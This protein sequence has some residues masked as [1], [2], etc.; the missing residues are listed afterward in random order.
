MSPRLWLPA[1]LFLSLGVGPLFAETPLRWQW[2]EN[3]QFFVEWR[4]VKTSTGE[5]LGSLFSS[6]QTTTVLLGFTVQRT[7]PD[8]GVVLEERI[9]SVKDEVEGGNADFLPGMLEGTVLHATL[10]HLGKVV[11][12]EGSQSVVKRIMG[13]NSGPKGDLL[14]AMVEDQCKGWLDDVFILLPE[15]PLPGGGKWEQ[16]TEMHLTGFGRQV[17]NKTFTDE[18]AVTIYGRQAH[19][20]TVQGTDVLLPPNRD[21]SAMAITKC[22]AKLTK[23]DYKGT[24][25]FDPAAGR[26]LQSETT[27]WTDMNTSFE[28][29][30]K[31]FEAGGT[32]NQTTK[33]RFLT[34]DPRPAPS[35]AGVDE[36]AGMVKEFTNSLG[37]KLVRIPRGQ[38]LMGSALTEE[39]RHESEHQ[40]LVEITHPFFMGVHEATIG[41]YRQFVQATGYQTFSEK[42]GKGCFGYNAAS[43]KVESGLIYSWKNPGW[44]HTDEHPVVNLSWF[45]AKAFC[46]WLSSKEGRTYRLPTEAEWEYACRAGTTTQYS[47]GTDPETLTAVGNVTDSSAKK[48]FPQWRTIRG[49]DGYTFTAPVGRFK[50][51]AFGLYD[52]HGNALEWC[53]DWYWLYDEESRKDPKGPPTGTH[54]IQ[55]GGSWAD[56]PDQCRSSSRAAFAP[57]SWC[58]SSGFRVVAEDL[59]SGEK[60]SLPAVSSEL[61]QPPRP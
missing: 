22:K 20:I 26:L 13:P 58:I 29:E 10:D 61:P 35:R 25:Y 57:V 51:N 23:G 45:D 60:A 28:L 8:G 7:T 44:E 47:S 3:E 39:G 5:R 42:S 50:P 18:G 43:G 37:M 27:L 46:D 48:V 52:M 2:K 40:H 53:A 31:T 1:A 36:N 56:F 34:R 30:G 6:Q 15:K 33:V 41:Q 38:F 24:L 16:Q 55:R 11:K 9:E 32:Q 17:R 54:R 49:D 21:E 14:Q 19:Q 59:P 12:V 4:M